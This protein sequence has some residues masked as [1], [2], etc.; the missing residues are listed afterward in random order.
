VAVACIIGIV[1]DRPDGVEDGTELK[2]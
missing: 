2:S 1:S